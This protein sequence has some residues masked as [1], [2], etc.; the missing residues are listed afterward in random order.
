MD[1]SRFADLGAVNASSLQRN[2]GNISAIFRALAAAPVGP[3]MI[4]CRA[5]RDRTGMVVA[6]LLDLGGVSRDLVVE[7]YVQVPV[8]TEN[9]APDGA[10]IRQMLDH[11]SREFDSTRGY[12]RWLGLA[13]EDVTA[14]GAL[15]LP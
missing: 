3:V 4:S 13:D 5:G 15:L 7:D 10:D 2:A 12:L 14:L 6:L 11:V 8:S 9:R 1:I